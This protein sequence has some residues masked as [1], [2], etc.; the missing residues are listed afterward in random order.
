MAEKLPQ[1]MLDPKTPA[2]VVVRDFPR[3]PVEDP[4]LGI[5]VDR[6]ADGRP[7]NRLVTI[8]DSLTHGFQSGAIFNTDISWPAI[9]ARELRSPRRDTRPPATL[10]IARIRGSMQGR[11]GG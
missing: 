9:V 11:E 2:E 7:R 6:E 5:E 8:G 3:E 10:G 1:S 4:T